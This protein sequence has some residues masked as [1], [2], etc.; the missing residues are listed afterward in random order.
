[1]LSK[2]LSNFVDSPASRRQVRDEVKTFILAGHETSAAM[3][4]WAAHELVKGGGALEALREEAGRVWP[5]SSCATWTEEQLPS[6]TEELCDLTYSEACLKEAL[7]L[8]S[9][10]PTVTRT[11]TKTTEIDGHT[12][13]KGTTVMVG[14]QAVHSD[15]AHWPEPKAYRPERFLPGAPE[16]KPYTFIPFIDGPRNCLGQYLALLESKVRVGV[17]L[18]GWGW[19][20]GG[21]GAGRGGGGGEGRRR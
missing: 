9:V 2:V 5:G 8:F 21:G 12:F 13:P 10:V 14:I 1:V 17:G 20:W 7:R 11:A 19:G 3:L 4:A 6:R 16:I 18:G 15:P